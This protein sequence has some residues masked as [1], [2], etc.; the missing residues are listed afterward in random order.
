MGVSQKLAGMAAAS[1]AAMVLVA[2]PVR[3]QILFFNGMPDGFNSLSS[4][5]NTAVGQSMVYDDFVVTGSTWHVTDLFGYFE[6]A[7]D[8]STSSAAWE[9]RTGVTVGDGGTLVA[10]GTGATTPFDTGNPL[11]SGEL[12]LVDI[13]GLSLDLAPGTYWMGIAN[14]GSGSGQ[15]FVATTD[16]SSG[17]VNATLDQMGF[18]TSSTFGADFANSND[19]IDGQD[20]FAY[21]ALGTTGPV[22]EPSTMALMAT[23]LVGLAGAARRRRRRA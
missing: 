5:Q 1:L 18:F 15:T 3:A 7:N 16:G 2:S 14:I 9:I 11:F 20:D 17:A 6:F 13:G 4:D 10:S 23:G 21:G 19:W 8:V 12:Y 22:P